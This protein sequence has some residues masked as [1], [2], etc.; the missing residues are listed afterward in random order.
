MV[1]K[2]VILRLVCKY[3][4]GKPVDLDDVKCLDIDFYRQRVRVS[5]RSASLSL[6]LLVGPRRSFV[7]DGWAQVAPLLRPEGLAEV[8]AALGEPLTFLLLGLWFLFP[9]GFKNYVHVTAFF[10]GLLK[11]GSVEETVVA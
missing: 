3:M 4:V 11:R 7:E 8:E 6:S 5:G 10:F 1:W 2:I 9:I